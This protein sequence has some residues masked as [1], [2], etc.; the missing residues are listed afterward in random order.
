MINGAVET[1]LTAFWN[2]QWERELLKS[3]MYSKLETWSF[4]VK[5]NC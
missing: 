2:R 1:V 4:L 3:E 5:N